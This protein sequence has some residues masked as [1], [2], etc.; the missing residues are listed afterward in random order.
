MEIN[1]NYNDELLKVID[2]L[3]CRPKLLLHSCCG[4]CS[5]Y[6]ISFLIDYFDV[7]VVYYNPCIEPEEEYLKRKREQIK[8]INNF[9]SKYKINFMESDYDNLDYTKLIKGH[10]LIKEGGS[11]CSICF[12]QRL[13]KVFK[14]AQDNHF[15]YFSTT[16]TVSPHKNAKLINAI[17]LSL[18]SD[19]TKFLVGDFKKNDGYKKSIELS[20]E[21]DLYRQ[22]YCGCIYSKKEMEK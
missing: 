1:V 6:V 21:Y 16:L 15:D 3:T 7:T 10:E 4:P 22:D 9:K 18:E 12:R 17:G 13:S 8:L 14:L 11:R 20:K 19:K 5:S 2:T